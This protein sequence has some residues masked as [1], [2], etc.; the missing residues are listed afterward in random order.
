[1]ERTPDIQ[2]TSKPRDAALRISVVYAVFGAIWI[3]FS[4]WILG[5]FVRDPDTLTH[6]AIIKGWVY[7]IVTALLIYWMVKGHFLT[8]RRSHR[9]LESSEHRYRAI[10]ETALEGIALTDSDGKLTFAN[11]RMAQMLAR[12]SEDLIGKPLKQFLGDEASLAIAD[13]LGS[14][15]PG[16]AGRC[17]IGLPR[18]G[19]GDLWA[20]ASVCPLFDEDRSFIGTLVMLTDVT[21]R[22]RLS[23]ELHQAQKI[24]A[25]G[26]L[27][28]GVAHDFNNL[29][30]AIFGYTDLARHT[31]PHGH[32]A[33]ASLEGVIAAAEQAAGVSKALL[34]FTRKA[35]TQKQIIELN[36][37]IAKA[38]QLL[39]RLLPASIELRTELSDGHSLFVNAD[40]TQIQQIILNLA[41]NARDAMPDGGVLKITAGRDAGS[42]EAG[43]ASVETT[44]AGAVCFAVSDTGTGMS[45]ETLERIFEP[46]FT[47]KPKGEG[48]GLG[49]SIIHGI[50]REHGGTIRVQSELGN[51]T[52]F[53]VLLPAVEAG[54]AGEE[55]ASIAPGRGLGELILLAED[56]DH[57][58]SIM[59]SVLAASGYEVVQVADG[60]ALLD[61]F[62]CNRERV[63]LIVS[64]V[65]MP[66]R[67]GLACLRELRSQGVRVPAIVTT[68]SLNLDVETQLDDQTTLLRQPYAMNVLTSLVSARLSPDR[69]PEA[70]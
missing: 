22:K 35:P 53:T 54:V 23:D 14:R 70:D 26:L 13:R 39:K 30:T 68:G 61:A 62:A 65:D 40:A 21:D 1:M 33:L 46:F 69:R 6:V 66:K 52:T 10:V 2:R 32:P 20:I 60:Q 44:A 12:R 63:R 67:S 41:V 24:E 34:T 5:A 28:G 25:V 15:M 18:S 49:L 4:D 55:A 64:D 48:T 43:P 31:L 27:A 7:V 19:G 9:L 16:A 11:A 50:V 56:N 47:T 42:S 51:G 36:Q 59:A 3:L 8:L 57:V 17:D 38:A 45:A 29:L 37:T 58:R